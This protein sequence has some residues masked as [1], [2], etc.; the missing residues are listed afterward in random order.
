MYQSIAAG[1]FNV[2]ANG[3]CR[4]FVCEAVPK[5]MDRVSARR[6]VGGTLSI[7]YGGDLGGVSRWGCQ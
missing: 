1:T 5:P 6:A 4:K 3:L 7:V 2:P